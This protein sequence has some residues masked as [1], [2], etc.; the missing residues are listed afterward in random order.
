MVGKNNED[1]NK[2]E[3]SKESKGSVRKETYRMEVGL[4]ELVATL[5]DS[6]RNRVRER[7]LCDSSIS[8]FP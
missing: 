2:H 1:L 4:W 6:H 8:Y 5:A 3:M 7:R